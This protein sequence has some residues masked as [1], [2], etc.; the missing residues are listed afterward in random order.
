MVTV[1]CACAQSIMPA[2]APTANTNCSAN[3]RPRVREGLLLR[4][5]LCVPVAISGATTSMFRA[6]L[7]TRLK[8]FRFMGSPVSSFRSLV[9]VVRGHPRNAS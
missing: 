1:D 7:K 8:M 3:A 2:A 4:E 5:D 9:V 6:L